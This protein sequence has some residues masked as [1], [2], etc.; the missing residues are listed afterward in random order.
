MDQEKF[1]DGDPTRI[2][3][4]PTFVKV[5]KVSDLKPGASLTVQVR[6]LEIALHHINHKFYAT[7]NTCPHRGGPLGEGVLEGIVVTCPWHGWQFNVCRGSSL[8]NPEVKIATYPV[9][10][11]G[12]DVFVEI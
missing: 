10:V 4:I 8:M 12:D 1:N 6:G 5:A 11:D 9:K 2:Q 3:S 7:T